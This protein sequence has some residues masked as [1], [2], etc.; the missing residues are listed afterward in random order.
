MQGMSG[1]KGV[2]PLASSQGERALA[3]P[4]INLLSTAG[5]PRVNRGSTVGFV[6]PPVYTGF[7]L[8]VLLG[9]P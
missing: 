2:G 5:Q 7:R 9:R 3:V 6:L 1:K 8:F 4:V